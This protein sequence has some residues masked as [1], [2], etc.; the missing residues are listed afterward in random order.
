MSKIK[1]GYG[2]EKEL[3][4]IEKLYSI[5][6]SRLEELK[7]QEFVNQYRN[8]FIYSK[9]YSQ[10]Y[11]KHGLRLESVQSIEDAEKIPIITKEDIRN[12]V[13]EL[14]TTNRMMV[15]KSFTSG[16]TGT[17]LKL[18]R[19]YASVCKEYSYGYNYQRIHGYQLGDKVISIK[20]DLFKNEIYRFDKSLNTLHLSSYNLN[21]KNIEKYYHLIQNFN[22]KVVK[23]YPSSLQILST[24]L[25]KKGL[26][27]NIP[28]AFTSSEVLHD[29]QR[30]IITKVLHSTIRDWYGNSEQSIAM[31]QVKEDLYQD[32]P[33]YGHI[34]VKEN[35]IITTGFINKS[36]PLIRYRI[37]D[38]I[39]LKC[40]SSCI[41]CCTSRILGRDNQYIILKDGQQVG[42]LDH[43]FNF[44]KIKNIL[45]A[46]IVQKKRG[47]MDL[48]LIP[49]YGFTDNNKQEILKNLKEL[50]G[51]D[52][53]IH[54]KEITDEEI[55]LSKSGKFNLMVSQLN[56][57]EKDSITQKILN[58]IEEDQ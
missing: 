18:Y 33:L 35:Y 17:P 14:L 40:D 39:K 22:P 29:F 47:E 15:Y 49:D 51:D 6:E 38:V 26:E 56:A 10:L 21:E 42:L 7:N 1:F 52:F 8:A 28:I 55:I 4:R 30:R 23:A 13:D 53:I 11:R 25:Y 46:Q 16:T 9:F 48:N 54:Y 34:E 58:E 19:D 12:R 50:L 20:G 3:K 45:A 32:I 36:F 31:G 44:N 37:D 27:L 41:R 2:F 43:A 24:E 5:S 57:E